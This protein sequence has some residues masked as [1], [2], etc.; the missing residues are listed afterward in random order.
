MAYKYETQ[1]NSP[2]FTAGSDTRAVWGVDRNIKNIAIHW[3]GDPNTNPTYEGVISTLCNPNRGAS[4]HFVVT[5]TGRRAA[6]LV[7]FDDNS[8][9]T[10]SDNPYS[11]SIECDPRCR[12]E[13]YD[14]VAEV[15][16]QIRDAFGPLP[17][18][19]HRQFI[20]TA[21]PGNYDLNRLNNIA[22]N[23]DGSGD[24]GDVKDKNAAPAPA[25]APAVKEQSRQDFN[26]Y[27]TYKFN[28]DSYLYNVLD[29]TKVN[30]TV[31][32]AGSKVT[33]AQSLILTNGNHWFRTPYSASKEIA[34]GFRAEDLEEVVTTPVNP[35]KDTPTDSGSTNTHSDNSN[36][37]SEN[38]SGV[39][40]DKTVSLDAGS[41]TLLQDVKKLLQQLLDT[42]KSIFKIGD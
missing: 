35:P 15:I 5:G 3:W 16:A 18:V 14:V 30:D 21:C 7:N 38:S 11:I 2:N 24:W 25:P 10:N 31:Y 33:I 13:D 20:Q 36:G 39:A 26:P 12:D 42:L 40:E 1:Y 22:N 6:Q 41:T 9:A 23:K 32:K 4:A 27:K 28:K 29:Y 37:N 34:S 8:W 19:P 17:L